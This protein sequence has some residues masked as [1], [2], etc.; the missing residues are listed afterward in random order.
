[1]ITKVKATD[2]EWDTD[3]KKISDLPDTTII[4]IEHEDDDDLEDLVADTLSDKFGFCI[5]SFNYDTVK[6][7]DY[8]EIEDED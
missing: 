6:D 5:F 4:E 8:E 2:I 1:M 3:G 7:G